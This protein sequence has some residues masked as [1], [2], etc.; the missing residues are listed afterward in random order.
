MIAPAPCPTQLA[1]TGLAANVICYLL[2]GTG[3]TLDAAGTGC[4]E[5]DSIVP[6]RLV[7]SAGCIR[8]C[9]LNFAFCTNGPSQPL[10]PVSLCFT[11]TSQAG[12]RLA[13]MC[14][15]G[16]RSRRVLQGS[17]AALEAFHSR[18]NG[19]TSFQT[20]SQQLT[21]KRGSC[22]RSAAVELMSWHTK[23]CLQTS[24]DTY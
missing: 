23:Q 22:V 16:C 20:G 21:G 6:E 3:R 9:C 4:T 11:C 17:D 10:T 13:A 24:I 19:F 14:D 15:A 12:C 8:L 5:R 7:R 1:R 18:G 2:R